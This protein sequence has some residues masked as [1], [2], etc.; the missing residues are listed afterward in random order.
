MVNSPGIKECILGEEPISRIN[1]IIS[2]GKGKEGSGSQTF[3]QHIMELYQAGK[4]S[5]ETATEA[6]T[7]ESDFI[8]KLLID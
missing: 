4:I 7:S 5:K 8:Q 2:Q 1:S 3:D 6:A